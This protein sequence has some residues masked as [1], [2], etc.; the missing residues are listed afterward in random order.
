MEDLLKLSRLGRSELVIEKVDLSSVAQDIAE[1]LSKSQPEREVIFQ[2]APGLLAM[3]DL[4]LL[5]IVM[6]NLLGNAWKFTSKQPQPRIEFGMRDNTIYFIRDNGAGFDLTY[7]AS[8]F[9]AFQRFHSEEEFSGTG[10]GLA[11]VNRIIHRHLG[12]IW[13]EAEPGKGALFSFTLW[14]GLIDSAD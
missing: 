3:G 1:R 2:I 12:R 6:E 10:M 11:V 14:E 13:A 4:S 5:R 7:S 8:L 9:G